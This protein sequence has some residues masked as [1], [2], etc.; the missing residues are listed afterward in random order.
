MYEKLGYINELSDMLV[1]DALILNTDRHLDNFGFL[2][3][4]D[5]GIIIGTAP[6]YDHNL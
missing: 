2:I 6:L 5:T 3:D 1:V 4:N